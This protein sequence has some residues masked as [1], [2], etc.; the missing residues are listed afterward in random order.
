M[1]ELKDS[2]VVLEES[3]KEFSDSLP[4]YKVIYDPLYRINEQGVKIFT[5]YFQVLKEDENG[6]VVDLG[7]ISNDYKPIS[8]KEELEIIFSSLKGEE[9]KLTFFESEGIITI[10]VIP[11]NNTIEADIIPYETLTRESYLHPIS[12]HLDK[13]ILEKGLLVTNSYAGEISNRI[14]GL[15]HRL[16][17]ENGLTNEF[18]VSFRH[19]ITPEKVFETLKKVFDYT[20]KLEILLKKDPEKIL[21]KH[22]DSREISEVVKDLKTYRV[23]E[24]II[25]AFFN[26]I[27]LIRRVR[28]NKVPVW[29]FVNVLTAL[30]THKLSNIYLKNKLNRRALSLLMYLSKN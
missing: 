8:L 7:V 28:E 14:Q 10:A 12:T 3:L 25:Q 15:Y 16:I 26:E 2:R 18:Q 13:E 5:G 30:T 4:S 27:G 24:E 6:K 9:V 20:G 19:T 21:K 1:L 23:K 29:D 22:I 17:C 11:E